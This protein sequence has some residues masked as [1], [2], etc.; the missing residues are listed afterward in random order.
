MEPYGVKDISIIILL[1]TVQ[2]FS[3]KERHV[4]GGGSRTLRVSENVI[5]FRCVV[6]ETIIGYRLVVLE[7]IFGFRLVVLKTSFECRLVV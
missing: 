3:D 7:T 2:Q 5:V 6:L 4:E 1:F